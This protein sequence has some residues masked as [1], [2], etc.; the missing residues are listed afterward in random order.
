MAKLDNWEYE[1]LSRIQSS[2]I[3]HGA[4]I[5]LIALAAGI[6]LGFSL[7]EG[8][9]LWPIL[10]LSLE[11]P[12][13]ERG[14][15]AAHT[16]GI[17]NGIMIIVVAISLVRIRLSTKQ[18]TWVYWLFVCTA[19]GNTIFYWFGNFSTN[20][21]LS[22]TATR[23]GDGDLYGAIAYLIVTPVM[24]LTVMGCWMLMREGFR[25]ARKTP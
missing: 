9:K 17:M 8:I 14:W 20:R 11:I 18:V 12:G 10:D 1:H 21:G 22:V 6:M 16:G 15:K 24:A 19:W 5:I 23:F 7:V 3:G 2:L 25:G 13:S 4:L